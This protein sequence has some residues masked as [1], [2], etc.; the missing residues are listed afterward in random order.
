M[1]V[2]VILNPYANRWRAGKMAPQVEA[3][4]QNARLDYDLVITTMPGHGTEEATAAAAG[5]Y[6]GVIAAGGDSTV[7]EVLNGLIA[8]AGDGPRCLWGCCRLAPAM[9]STIWPGCHA[10]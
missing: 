7:G 8:V 1:K 6:D 5:G 3:A 10:P 2:K 4:F 9:I